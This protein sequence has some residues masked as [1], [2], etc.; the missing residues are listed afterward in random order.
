MGSVK[1][2]I[3]T[4]ELT[5]PGGV[6]GLLNLLRLDQIEGIEYFCVNASKG[7]YSVLLLPFVYLK[8]FLKVGKFDTVHLNPS[9]NAKSFYRDM[10][11]AFI[12]K[13]I[14]KKR[15]IVYWH[16]WQGDFFHKVKST[17]LRRLLFRYSFGLADTH[18]VLANEFAENLKTIGYKGHILLE[19]NVAEKIPTAELPGK[20][21]F[22]T[23]TLLYLSRITK[24]KGWDLALETMKIIQD[25]GVLNIRLVVAG[26]GDCLHAAQALARK[27]ELGNV[28]FA[29]YVQGEQKKQLLLTS[30]ILFFPTCYPEGMPVVILEGMMFGLPI[31]T[32][33]VGGIADHISDSKNGYVTDSVDPRDFATFIMNLTADTSRYNAIR[34][35]NI[36]QSH[37]Q[38]VP[39]RLVQRLLSI[40]Q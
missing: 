25:R 12:A 33:R 29:G 30:D 20:T 31:I 5:L 40:Y 34:Q 36:K 16:G 35:A 27:L 2:L 7:K 9:M 39:E 10:V 17:S 19:S 37:E 22:Q 1:V 26:D 38:F 21:N 8:F 32:R 3:T 11:F 6:T 23:W 15:L 24:D 14:F 18:L 28:V 13:A 4:P